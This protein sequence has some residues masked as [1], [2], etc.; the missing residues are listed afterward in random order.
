LIPTPTN[1]IAPLLVDARTA[2]RML[3]ISERSLWAATSPRGPIRCVR[4]GKRGI[5]YDINALKEFVASAL[6]DTGATTA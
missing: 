1:E 5:R 3:A 2:A 6:S 4:I